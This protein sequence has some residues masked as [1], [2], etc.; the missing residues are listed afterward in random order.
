MPPPILASLVAMIRL[1]KSFPKT[2][3]SSA[4]VKGISNLIISTRHFFEENIKKR[5]SLILEL[6]DMEKKFC[7]S[8]FENLEY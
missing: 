5:M 6:W 3:E 2:P 4:R 1:V 7:L 8:R